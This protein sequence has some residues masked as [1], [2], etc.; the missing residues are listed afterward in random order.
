[1]EIWNSRGYD[2]DDCNDVYATSNL[3]VSTPYIPK[4]IPAVEYT[5]MGESGLLKGSLGLCSMTVRAIRKNSMQEE[6]LYNS[7]AR[8]QFCHCGKD[9]SPRYLGVSLNYK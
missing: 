3:F 5:L 9:I 8:G 1:M 2:R 4:T 7:K 6:R